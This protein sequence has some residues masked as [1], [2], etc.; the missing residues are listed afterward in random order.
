MKWM[1]FSVFPE[2]SIVRITRYLSTLVISAAFSFPAQAALVASTGLITNLRIEGNAGFVGLEHTLSST[3]TCGSRV[4][5]DMTT[6]LGRSIYATAMMALAAG[7][8]VVVRAFEESTRVFGECAL[9]DI[10]VIQ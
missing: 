1:T 8:T 4:W 10:Y 6:I 7:K 9:Y 2:R 5:V 3:S